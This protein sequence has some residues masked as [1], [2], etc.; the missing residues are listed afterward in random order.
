MLDL[1]YLFDLVE[2]SRAALDARPEPF[3]L[4]GVRFDHYP[5]TAL[6]GVI[7]LSPDSSYRETVATSTEA[8]IRR[9]R[10]LIADGARVLDIGAES[11]VPGRE[12]L[13][14]REQL[15]R[16]L[17]V[18]EALA[19][20]GAVVSVETYSAEL[21]RE[22]LRAGARLIN[23]T[24]TSDTGVIYDLAAVFEAG[25]II[26]YLHGANPHGVDTFSP[27]EEHR[28]TLA[29]YFT[30]EIAKARAA[31]VERTWIDPG[32]TFTYSDLLRD[33]RRRAEYQMRSILSGFRLRTLGAPICQALP[34]A[35]DFFEDEVR[36]GEVFYAVLALLGRADL[37]RTHEVT[38]VRGVLRTMGAFGSGGAR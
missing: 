18:I 21:A 25:V 33:P 32:L 35:F 20:N 15:D 30:A 3:E 1:S 29:E 31:G 28:E 36:C 17:P 37:L 24:S 2:E 12:R 10:R 26:C 22:C 5:G 34:P 16:L 7:N 19:G 4:G 27:G 9:G 38:K 14:A 13:T 6:M 23:L 8:A 11:S